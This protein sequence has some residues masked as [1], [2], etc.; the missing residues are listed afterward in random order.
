VTGRGALSGSKRSK[1]IIKGATISELK[2]ASEKKIQ[3]YRKG[4]KFP[5]GENRW[6][7]PIYRK[8]S[9]LRR[10]LRG[11]VEP[12]K[13]KGRGQEIADSILG[14]I[15]IIWGQDASF[16]RKTQDKPKKSLP[17]RTEFII[18][19]IKLSQAVNSD[20]STVWREERNIPAFGGTGK[21]KL[22]FTPN[23]IK[24][25]RR[26][27]TKEEKLWRFQ[28]T[29]RLMRKVRRKGLELSVTNGKGGST[30]IREGKRRNS[31][32]GERT[33]YSNASVG[34]GNTLHAGHG[35]TLDP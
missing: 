15:Y 34:H 31:R 10:R 1:S 17:T 14:T 21:L 2:G 9:L 20:N 22:V 8:G 13:K 3:L 33:G 4:S 30:P 11:P 5:G 19:L 27:K 26:R 24:H 6:P 29:K 28:K 35:K 16:K 32:I 18:T 23:T 12:L 25:R 7:T